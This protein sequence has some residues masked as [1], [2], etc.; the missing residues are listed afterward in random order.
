MLDVVISRIMWPINA[1]SQRLSA[2][3]GFLMDVT[4]PKFSSVLARVGLA[5]L[6]HA[7]DQHSSETAQ[8]LWEEARR[9][10]ISMH[11][12]RFLGLPRRMFVASY[13]GKTCVFEGLPRPNRRQPSLD[14]IDDKAELKSRFLKAGFP[15]ARGDVCRTEQQ[16]LVLLRSLQAPVITKPHTGSGGRHTTV[17]IATG[18]ELRKGFFNAKQLSPWVIVEEELQ[19][20][21]FRATL[22]GG[23]LVAVLRR[24]PPHVVGDGV[25][26]ITEL[27]AEENSNPLREGPVFAKIA[28]GNI[29]PNYIPK[30][31]ENVFFH[32]KVN[33]GVGGTSRDSTDETHPLNKQLFEN[34]GA[35]LSDDIIGIDFMVPN[36]SMPWTEQKRCGVIE[37]N[38]LPLI[39]NHHF[40][41]TGPR[42]NVAGAVWDL[43]FPS[44]K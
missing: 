12:V 3:Y 11:E 39:G 4:V 13:Q 5:S 6:V 31:S 29:D 43:V 40:P 34:I 21:V 24:D 25:H 42:V 35:Y 18:E 7:P 15:V 36:I 27:V 8:C 22:V 38:S 37:C 33:W 17:H 9:R 41:F 19:G 10:G 28:L 23:K 26:T 44:S 2:P 20:P 14:W 1:V 32:F 16:A 30:K